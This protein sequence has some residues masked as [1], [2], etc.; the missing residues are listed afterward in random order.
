MC[1]FYAPG[2]SWVYGVRLQSTIRTSPYGGNSLNSL[3]DSGTKC[4]CVLFFFFVFDAGG[5]WTFFNFIRVAT[6]Y[7]WISGINAGNQDLTETMIL[8]GVGQG[9]QTDFGQEIRTSVECG[10]RRSFRHT[11]N[12][13]DKHLHVHVFRG[14]SRDMRLENL[15]AVHRR[16]RP[17]KYIATSCVRSFANG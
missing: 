10:R 17:S 6:G 1:V 15:N 7:R 12:V 14:Q 16:T 13:P 8:T 9:D 3:D 4:W 5:S 11:D 2:I